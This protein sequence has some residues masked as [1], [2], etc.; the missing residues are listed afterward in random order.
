[1]ERGR[2]TT[3]PRWRRGVEHINGHLQ[4]TAKECSISSQVLL[5]RL[6]TPRSCA[7]V[8]AQG[9]GSERRFHDALLGSALQLLDRVQSGSTHGRS[10]TSSGWSVQFTPPP[11]RGSFGV[12][13]G[14]VVKFYRQQLGVELGALLSRP[15]FESTAGQCSLNLKRSNQF[16]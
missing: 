8:L 14:S 15:S 3:P 4:S 2:D 16:N 6:W 7:F 11:T 12:L 9:V 10:S 13:L 1:M 5:R